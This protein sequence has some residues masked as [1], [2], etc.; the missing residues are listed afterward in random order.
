MRNL[1]MLAIAALAFLCSFTQTANAQVD[2]TINPVGL[3]FG[4]LS[5]GADFTLT[6]NFSLEAAVGFGTNKIDEIKGTNIPVNV[7]GKY[8]FSPKNGADR[9]YVDAFLRYVNRQWKYD[10]NSNYADF[11]SNRF[12]VGFGLGYKVVSKG[13]FVF[14]I[15]FGAGR[16]LIDNNTYEENDGIQQDVDWPELML[17]GKLGIGYRFGGSK[18]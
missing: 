15:G 10:D 6:E 17:Q 16:A 2:V 18:K 7:V 13:G 5:V 12:G 9:F 14:D 11:T 3:L 8:Y 1:S 4:D